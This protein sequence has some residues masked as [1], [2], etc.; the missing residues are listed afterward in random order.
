[1]ALA[2]AALAVFCGLA[3]RLWIT[4]PDFVLHW[5][6][7]GHRYFLAGGVDYEYLA[8]PW[9]WVTH[10]DY[11]HL[12][13][14]L[15]AATA[16]LLGRFSEPA[17]LLWSGIWLAATL[18]AARE[19]AR[20]GGAGPDLQAAVLAVVALVTVLAG[21]G[22]LM[23]GGADWLLAFVA[24]AALVPLL[25]PAG[26][27]ADLQVGL[28]A[29]LAAASKVE[30]VA[31]GGFLVAVHFVVRWRTGW[32]PGGRALA[33]LALPGVVVVGAWLWGV[34][35]WELLGE[36]N[37]GAFAPQR[38][39]QVA[40]A[41]WQAMN[42][43]AWHGVSWTLVALLALALGARRTRPAAVVLLLQLLVYLYAYFSARVDVALLVAT[44]WARLLLHL[45]PA[46]IVLGGVALG[47][48]RRASP[49]A[50]ATGA[51]A[52]PAD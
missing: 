36:Y 11:P 43:R 26:A 39:P 45:L 18:A 2:A 5:G 34:W 46:A 6:L 42:A 25:D 9:N 3:W 12:L 40:A 50:R 15:Y 49:A 22:H 7:K 37:L 20:R 41:L 23:A 13:P 19:A 52:A 51:T 31:L 21:I 17:M 38:L 48:K 16:L 32:R 24:V 28:L 33:S 8:R 47:G 27:E 10:P 44:S 35:R 30:G 1:M 29:A 4:T 14:E